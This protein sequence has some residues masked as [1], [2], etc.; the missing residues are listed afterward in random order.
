MFYLIIYVRKQ[1]Y[2]LYLMRLLT[3]NNIV[4]YIKLHHHQLNTIK[5]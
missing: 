2:H 4:L 1:K 5:M 3:N